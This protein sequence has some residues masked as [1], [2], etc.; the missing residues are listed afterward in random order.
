MTGVPVYVW[1]PK[2]FHLFSTFKSGLY[3]ED[4][5]EE[6]NPIKENDTISCSF[7]TA[8]D[9]SIIGK[10]VEIKGFLN[11]RSS[12]RFRDNIGYADTVTVFLNNC[13]II[14]VQ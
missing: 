3:I 10:K 12:V 9:K 4:K 13:K 6:F 8:I 7:S 11:V 2:C 14:S 5:Y 1:Y